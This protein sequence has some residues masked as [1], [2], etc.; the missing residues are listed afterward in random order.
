MMIP[1]THS[2]VHHLSEITTFKLET[3]GLK[4]SKHRS[5]EPWAIV[6]KG[7][8]FLFFC[9]RIPP[10]LGAAATRGE[11]HFVILTL[12]I[13]CSIN[14]NVS[15]EGTE[16]RM[17]KQPFESLITRARFCLKWTEGLFL[18]RHCWFHFLP[19]FPPFDVAL[20]TLLCLEKDDGWWL[21]FETEIDR[22]PSGPWTLC[23]DHYYA[24]LA[25]ERVLKVNRLLWKGFGV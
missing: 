9:S 5:H 25:G 17:R 13:C 20:F 7:F 10:D 19:L 3:R 18:V 12:F 14:S 21:F 1:K 16:G 4:S 22:T 8:H 2:D 15:R 23:S 6:S 11:T 24:A